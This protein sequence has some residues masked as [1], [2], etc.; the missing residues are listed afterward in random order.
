[1]G[2]QQDPIKPPIG[3]TICSGLG[4]GPCFSFLWDQSHWSSQGTI[5]WDA[6]VWVQGIPALR[7]MDGC[8]GDIGSRNQSQ[9]R[10]GLALPQARPRVL[11]SLIAVGEEHGFGVT[12]PRPR[13][14][15]QGSTKGPTARY[16]AVP[17]VSHPLIPGVPQPI[18]L[19]D[20]PGQSMDSR[21]PVPPATRDA[22]GAPSPGLAVLASPAQP[23]WAPAPGLG[24][25]RTAQRDGPQGS[26]TRRR[27]RSRSFPWRPVPA[28][29]P[30]RYRHTAAAPQSRSHRFSGPQTPASVPVPIPV[31][32]RPS[33][34]PPPPPPPPPLRAPE[35]GAAP[36]RTAP[37]APS[38]PTNHGQA[39]PA[40]PR[41]FAFRLVSSAAT[42]PL[43]PP[44][45][46]APPTVPS[47]GPA[48]SGPAHPA[49]AAGTHWLESA[50]S[51]GARRPPAPPTGGALRR[52]AHAPAGR[53]SHVRGKGGK[54]E[55]GL[56]QWGRVSTSGH[57]SSLPGHSQ[58][59][60]VA[61]PR[62]RAAVELQNQLHVPTAT[63]NWMC[64]DHRFTCWP[65]TKPPVYRKSRCEKHCPQRRQRSPAALLERRNSMHWSTHP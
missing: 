3:N 29:P 20:A 23:P 16:P 19:S 14:S 61:K 34:S 42:P 33:P 50:T 46:R 2:G 7:K 18:I 45:P 4:I 47:L 26:R 59:V 30:P 21:G 65:Y 24:T 17:G 11:G 22:D 51:S 43:C 64:R 48:P 25:A 31:T 28:L 58:P 55:V 44:P 40:S 56:G 36:R 54:A 5:N 12:P 38:P 37:R 32:S 39:T 35:V 53:Q 41:R 13:V 9:D 6:R 57:P 49:V 10:N 8:K 63:L 62:A 1:M 52:T 60:G 15:A 27:R